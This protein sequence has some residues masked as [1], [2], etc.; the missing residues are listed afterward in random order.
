MKQNDN[1]R[2]NSLQCFFFFF[3]KQEGFYSGHPHKTVTGTPVIKMQSSTSPQSLA[4]K[5]YQRGVWSLKTD[6]RTERV[7]TAAE[8]V[9]WMCCGL[10]PSAGSIYSNDDHKPKYVGLTAKVFLMLQVLL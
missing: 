3:S 4:F 1:R 8:F 6:K 2:F 5:K 7:T 9:R 10:W